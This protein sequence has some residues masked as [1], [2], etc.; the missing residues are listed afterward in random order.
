MKTEYGC[1]RW[2]F[3]VGKYAVKIPQIKYTWRHFLQGLLCNM[4]EVLFYSTKDERLCPI[5]WHIP[6]GWMV[7]MKRCKPLT[8]TEFNN[9]DM[10]N[11]FW[12]N[13]PYKIPVE[14]KID[15]FGKLDGK[16]VAVDYGS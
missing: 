6:G 16:I 4:Q 9:I 10:A 14:Y 2:V 5:L 11:T 13:T 3:L 7:V 8:D 15:S 12:N 1:T